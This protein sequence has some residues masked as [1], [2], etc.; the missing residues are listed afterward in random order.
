MD[1]KHLVPA[2][3]HAIEILKYLSTHNE[4]NTLTRISEGISINK[5]SC[6]RILKT[7]ENAKFVT[8]DEQARE[9]NLGSFLVV[10]GKQAIEKN[11]YLA[12][13]KKYLQDITKNTSM[14]SLLVSRMNENRL[15]VVAREE[16]QLRFTINVG[17]HFH[18][19]S[20]SYGKWF[21]ANEDEET[22]EYF[23]KKL[24]KTTPF[25][26]TDP[27]QFRLS[28][29]TIKQKGYAVSKE[30]YVLGVTAISAPVFDAEGKLSMV[31][32]CVG[33]AS[34]LDEEECV[35]VGE[36]LRKVANEFSMNLKGEFLT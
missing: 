1:N 11:N 20:S 3:N 35:R 5:S 30:E 7:L 22:L 31:I 24:R 15:M 34:L 32:A 36:Y 6:M 8:Y 27:E 25:T 28:L 23:I 13:G 17:N 2:V 16:E 14:S 9:Y 29:A 26:I 21:L 18:I 12:L 4:N 33:F 10:L 19:L